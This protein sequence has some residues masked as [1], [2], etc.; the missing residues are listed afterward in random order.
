MRLDFRL[1]K[2]EGSEREISKLSKL[3]CSKDFLKT[4]NPFEI[5]IFFVKTAIFNAIW[6]WP[7]SDQGEEKKVSH[8]KAYYKRFS[9]K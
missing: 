6:A 8:I 5:N 9:F 4:K 7:V 3:Q 1:S 2:C